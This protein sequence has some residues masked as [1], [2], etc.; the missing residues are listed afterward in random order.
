MV[1]EKRK[2]R[3]DFKVKQETQDGLSV[4]VSSVR[5]AMLFVPIVTISDEVP[6]EYKYFIIPFMTRTY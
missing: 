4:G 6:Y 3:H 1:R 5:H 2:V